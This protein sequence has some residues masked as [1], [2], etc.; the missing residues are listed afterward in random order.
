MDF[1]QTRMGH[2]FFEG[3]MPQLIKA[4]EKLAKKGE[5][6]EV[7][8]HTFTQ[9]GWNTADDEIN[10]FIKQNAKRVIDV[11]TAL[12]SIS[13]FGDGRSELCK[14]YMVIYVPKARKSE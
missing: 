13:A 4:L 11:K 5:E 8:V 3:R 7:C 2:E 6:E 12:C 1:F 14:E 9:S 10:A